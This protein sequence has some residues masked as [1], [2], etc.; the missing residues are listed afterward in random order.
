MRNPVLERQ[1]KARSRQFCRIRS[2]Y[3][4]NTHTWGALE[5]KKCA[6]ATF[7][8]VISPRASVPKL[9]GVVTKETQK[10]AER[11]LP[12]VSG[13]HSRA[14]AGWGTGAE[15]PRFRNRPLGGS[16]ARVSSP[17]AFPPSRGSRAGEL[18]RP[19]RPRARHGAT[20]PGG[21]EELQE[22]AALSAG[23]DLEKASRA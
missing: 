1:R 4:E 15:A 7:H 16:S 10:G 13:F 2:K 11:R 17:G 21:T 19:S 12:S 14:G 8:D 23:P 9:P 18:A 3:K 22:A 20:P 6:P 5:S